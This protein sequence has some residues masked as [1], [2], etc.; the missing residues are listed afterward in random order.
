MLLPEPAKNAGSGQGS[1]GEEWE[2]HTFT[3]DPQERSHRLP[4]RK[5]TA[6]KEPLRRSPLVDFG[7][8]VLIRRW[9]WWGYPSPKALS[10]LIPCEQVRNTGAVEK[11][12]STNTLCH[13]RYLKFAEGPTLRPFHLANIH[14][15]SNE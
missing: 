13:L 3:V 7:C 14:A 1:I 6:L 12:L 4:L 11:R 8:D 5:G 15:I 2:E 9:I 10:Q